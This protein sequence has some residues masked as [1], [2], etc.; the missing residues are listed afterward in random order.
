[1]IRASRGLAAFALVLSGALHVAGLV[2]FRCDEQ[3]EI[4]GG[5]PAT[6][7]RLGN[8]F[9]DVAQGT[10]HPVPPEEMRDSP[11]P[12]T[13]ETPSTSERTQEPS[14]PVEIRQPLETARP[15]T[16]PPPETSTTRATPV[17]TQPE[18]IRPLDIAQETA[19]STAPVATNSVTEPTVPRV[20]ARVLTRTEQAQAS[21]QPLNALRTA[22]SAPQRIETTGAEAAAARDV[23]PPAPQEIAALPRVDEVPVVEAELLELLEAV[24]DAAPAAAARADGF[25]AGQQGAGTGARK[26]RRTADGDADGGF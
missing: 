7:A 8:S 19:L 16:L 22:P 12:E 11:R 18:Q 2:A 10:Q 9:R 21:V 5:A 20:S 6:A 24:D 15:E 26:H 1:M 3:V 13:V 23:E 4:E 14:E 17:A 25:A